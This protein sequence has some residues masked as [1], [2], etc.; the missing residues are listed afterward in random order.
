MSQ[1]IL[2]ITMSGV[3]GTFAQKPEVLNALHQTG[4]FA[5]NATI[6]K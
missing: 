4:H 5:I 6:L 2:V 3:T 1:T